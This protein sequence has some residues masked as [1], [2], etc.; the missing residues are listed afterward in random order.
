MEHG[1]GFVGEGSS[2]Y[3]RAPPARRSSSPPPVGPTAEDIEASEQLAQQLA[4]ENERDE[5]D[6]AGS[7]I[8]DPLYYSNVLASSASYGGGSSSD[9][10]RGVFSQQN[11]PWTTTHSEKEDRLAELFRPPYDIIT[12]ANLEAAR[13]QAKKE[14][15]KIMVNYQDLSDFAC[16]VLNRDIWSHEGLQAFI[17]E[18]FVFLQYTTDEQ[19][20][21]DYQIRYKVQTFPHVAIIDP[22]TGACKH[23]WNKI[24]DP[25]TFMNEVYIYMN[26]TA[27]SASSRA[28]PSQQNVDYLAMTDE[29]RMAMAIAASRAEYNITDEDEEAEGDGQQ[30]A[31]AGG[32]N[33]QRVVRRFNKQSHVAQLFA[34]IREQYPDYGTQP[35]LELR[36]HVTL[37]NDLLQSTLVEAGAA[38]ASVTVNV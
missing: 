16:Q 35:T 24:D 12:R 21:Q 3:S 25:E 15:K 18:H 9:G 6:S 19:E 29:E 5:L 23:V 1:P 13:I 38:G 31:E 7:A 8:R 26:D 10:P 37:L 20:G 2:A 34:F 32:T 33:G 14:K 30:G 22:R 11:H 27:S 36:V 17:R 4:A 28:T